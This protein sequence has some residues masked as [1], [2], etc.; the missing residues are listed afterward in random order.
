M[1]SRIS[2]RMRRRRNQCNRANVCSITIEGLIG[3]N[4]SGVAHA[5]GG[6]LKKYMDEVL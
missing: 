1:S 3:Y 2:Q 6:V 4:C 5:W